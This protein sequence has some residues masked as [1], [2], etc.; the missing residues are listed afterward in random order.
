MS[1]IDG[2]LHRLRV[3][4][5]GER[6]ASEQEREVEFHLELETM[7]QQ[8]PGAGD[9][10]DLLDAPDMR[11]AARRAFGNVT[12]YREES[13]RVS[14]LH[15]LDRVRQDLHYAIRGLGRQPGFTAMVVVT[16]ALGFGVNAAMFSMLNRL[17]THQPDGV[18]APGEVRRFYNDFH[19][20]G[21]ALANGRGVQV[22]DR[23][24]YP[25]FRAMRRAGVG[26][27]LALVT[28]P[29]SVNVGGRYGAFSARETEVSSAYFSILGLRPAVGRF[30]VAE[31]D[32][33]E[34]PRPVAV[35]SEYL[36]R[37]RFGQAPDVLGASV[38][39]DHHPFTIV[40]VAP[41]TFRGIDLD[42]VDVW[43]PLN[44]RGYSSNDSRRWYENFGLAARLIARVRSRADEAR[45]VTIVQNAM[46]TTQIPGYAFD[47]HE[48]VRSG[49]LI[50]GRGP[51]DPAKEASVLTRISAVALFVLI[52]AVANVVNLLLLRAAN[53]RREL[54]L[55]RA[56]GISSGRLIW[57][58]VLE[59]TL[60][61]VIAG[62][63]A[64]V[65]AAWAGG[66][67]RHLV[68]PATHWATSPVDATTASFVLC[69][70]LLIGLASGVAPA[71]YGLDV[72][73]ADA[74]KAGSASSG[75]HRSATRTALLVVQVGLCVVLLVGAGLFAKS[76]SNVMSIDT[77][78]DVADVF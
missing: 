65:I 62:V 49:S 20:P 34:T 42:A 47:P 27:A 14:A 52:I 21:T 26:D 15:L 69:L 25:H 66:L 60:L 43:V 76:L 22:F 29:D 54:A 8:S 24:E 36:W 40:G 44:T 59:G 10:V 53:R 73:L 63:V 41:P 48:T 56:L 17:F 9:A 11:T 37:T 55:R 16:L 50:A 35:I 32:S 7:A 28:E 64:M 68:M 72:Q 33:I 46:Q 61:S 3:L 45:L 19:A 4:V 71:L 70:S 12:Y 2:L 57:Q 38:I 74:L 67:L 13:R 39:I 23:Y 5:R 78:Y 6:Y 30:F 77:G 75:S 18:V 31:E 51:A 1:L 58:L